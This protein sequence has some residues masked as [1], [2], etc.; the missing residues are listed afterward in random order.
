MNKKLACISIVSLLSILSLPG[1][2]AP[3][4]IA[5]AAGAG[6]ASVSGSSIPV[7]TQI[8]DT[9]IKTKII[10]ILNNMNSQLE[11]QSNVE[12]TVFN[13]IVLLLGQVPSQE[14]RNSIATQTSE[15]Q[16]VK[17]VYNQLTVGQ[18]VSLG[19]Y[20]NDAWITTK[21]KANMVG[22]IDPLHFKVVTQQGVVYL[23]GQVTKQEGDLA[24]NITR[25]TAG[26]KRVV[27]VFS[28]IA[29]PAQPVNQAVQNP[30]NSSQGQQMTSASSSSNSEAGSDASD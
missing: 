21:V 5:G 18:S 13:G 14:I 17:L 23:L 22:Q 30:G 28:Y 29:A 26:V 19:T 27:Q 25:Q 6:A 20:S 15:I 24:A 4:L 16:G 1:C 11:Y 8:N 12:V 9:S 10:A 2:F 7:S 3:I